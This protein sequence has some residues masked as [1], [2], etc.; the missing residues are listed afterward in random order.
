MSYRANGTRA[1][2]H[3]ANGIRADVVA[4]P[5]H[6]YMINVLPL[7][8]SFQANPNA[9]LHRLE[10]IGGCWTIKIF[11]IIIIRMIQSVMVWCVNGLRRKKKITT[12]KARVS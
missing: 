5:S 8:S 6:P 9:Q 2:G 4:P 7:D 10:G 3:R 11:L 1:N 12:T